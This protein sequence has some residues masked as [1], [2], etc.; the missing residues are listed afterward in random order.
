MR[1]FGRLLW[2]V[3]RAPVKGALGESG[4]KVGA[5]LTLPSSVYR[6]YHDVTLTTAVGNTTQI[7]HVFVSVFGIFVVET[8]NKGGWIFGSER[9]REWTQTFPNGQKYKFQNPLRQN[10]GHV[11][12][13]Q[14]V[15]NGMDLPGGIVKSVVVFVGDAEFKTEMPENVT[16]GFGAAEYIRSFKSQVLTAVQVLQICAVIESA[17]MDQS[18]AT[19]QQHVRNLKKWKE[20]DQRRC[21]RCGEQMVLRTTQRGP[22]EGRQFWGCKSFPKCRA[23]E[24]T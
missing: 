11:K 19:N 13:I 23:I 24:K 2:S 3:F 12:A 14:E 16:L 15:L 6:R 20:S 21:P 1:T 18:W 5:A 17:R 4:V 10:Y 9:G 8:K 22:N 7:D